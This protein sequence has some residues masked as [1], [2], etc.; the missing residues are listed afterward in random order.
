M[1][2]YSTLSWVAAEFV[3][4]SCPPVR[5]AQAQLPID[6][7]VVAEKPT[8]LRMNV[9]VV[10]VASRFGSGLP[11]AAVRRGLA[12]CRMTIPE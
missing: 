11:V 12:A 2:R 4:A 10:F 8:I 6:T 3:I 7:M 5:V 1:P 9:G